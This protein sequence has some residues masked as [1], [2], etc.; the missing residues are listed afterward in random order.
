M[1]PPRYARNKTAL[2]RALCLGRNS[3]HELSQ[4]PDFPRQ[5]TN[6]MW[7]IPEVQKWMRQHKLNGGSMVAREQLQTELLQAKLEREKF[8]LNEAKAATRTQITDEFTDIFTSAMWTI[9]AALD[10]MVTEL[11]PQFEGRTPGEIRRL[12]HERQTHAFSEIAAAF[13]R[14]TGA[15]VTVPMPNVVKFARG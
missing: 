12:F 10:R 9:R 1:K 14:K 6:G 15:S 13:N 8:L 2:A 3:I 7:S 11:S 5:S 4:Q